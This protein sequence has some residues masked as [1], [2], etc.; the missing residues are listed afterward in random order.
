MSIEWSCPQCGHG[1]MVGDEHAGKTG[2]CSRCGER[3]RMPLPTATDSVALRSPPAAPETAP[4]APPPD[5]SLF[6]PVAYGH[7]AE[8]IPAGEVL[9][10]IHVDTKK[11]R[12]QVGCIFYIL[13][14]WF[15]MGLLGAVIVFLS[16]A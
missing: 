7:R 5:E 8:E 15:G 6:S 13:T 12:E 10:R 2:T 14:F 1:G 9:W 4:K 3:I 11:M 16:M